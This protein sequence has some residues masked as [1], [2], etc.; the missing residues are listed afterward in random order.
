M[1]QNGADV[2]AI[3]KRRGTPLDV[4][5]NERLKNAVREFIAKTLVN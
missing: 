4:C 3:N 2:Q 5:R 1:I